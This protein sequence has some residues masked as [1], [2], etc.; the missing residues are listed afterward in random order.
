MVP[1]GR[2]GLLLAAGL[3]L[4]G[5]PR[6]L[7][8]QEAPPPLR[9][10]E[11]Y[12]QLD[13]A[14]PRLSAA[15]AGSRAALER[16]SALRTL[17]DPQIQLGL[18][19]RNLSGLGLQDPLGMNQIQ[20]M[21]MVPFPGKLGAAGRAATARAD[22][23]SARADD[24]RWEL[25]AEAAMT[26]YDI[27]GVDRSIAVAT[28]SQA[29]LRDIAATAQ[30]MYSVGEGPQ[31]NVLR[32]QVEVSRMTE[33]LLRMQAMREAMVARLNTLLD[34]APDSPVGA[35][36]LPTFPK[37][38]P[39][40]DSLIAQALT[41]RPMLEAGK[42]DVQ[43]ADANRTLAQREIWPDFQLGAIYGQRPMAGGGT[44]RMVSFMLGF[45]IPVF[46]GSRQLPMRREADAM[47]EMAR[48]DLGAMIADTRGR[49]G[50]LYS[51]L[52]RARSLRALYE[53]DLL[54]QTEAAVT[55]SLGAYRVGEVNLMTLLDARMTVYRYQQERYQLEAAEGK[56]W[57]ELEMLL[58]SALLD[59]D[60]PA[61]TVR[62]Q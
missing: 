15:R 43:A 13:A 50:V 3:L 18:M 24:L 34:R 56:A 39:P 22:A 62:P 4:G 47:R 28:R 23:S 57:A 35:P 48:A 1:P 55:A 53:T 30:S 14:S 42:R 38:L 17:P 61:D 49:V 45:S 44:D 8:A 12:R 27:Y 52:R 5:G 59:V 29:L 20:V 6:S 25:R 21:Q 54:P 10:G 11:L 58:G 40:L 32:A 46:A 36:A 51:E 37:E 41:G 26:F 31:A 16:V 60:Q 7:P 2:F 19:N 9:L 33:E